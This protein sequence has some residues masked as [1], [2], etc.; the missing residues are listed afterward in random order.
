MRSSRRGNTAIIVGLSLAALLGAAAVVIDIGYGRLVRLELQNAADATALAAVTRFD[1]TDEG[2][3]DARATGVRIAA[4]NRAAGTGVTLD[5]NAANAPDGDI[6]LGVYD[7]TDGSFTPS[8]DAEVVNAA[9]V[10]ARIPDLGL[11]IAPMALNRPTLA[12]GAVSRTVREEGGAEAVDCF[13]PLGMPSCLVDR[14]ETGGL[15]NVTL[16]FQPT[17]IDNVG[18]ARPGA[19]PNASWS[20][21]QLTNCQQSGEISIGD[22]LGLQNG[23]AVSVLSEFVTAVESSSTRWDT[24][25]WG[26]LPARNAQSSIAAAKYGRTFEG[27]VPVFDGG[28]AY[29]TPGGGKFNGSAPISGFVWGA[30]YEVINKGPSSNRTIMMRLDFTKEYDVGTEVGGPDW[31]VKAS[32]PPRMLPM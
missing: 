1:G 22:S 16:K 29:C 7:E 31:S 32:E 21:S 24:A 14:Y 25:K 3:A 27:V 20:R 23:T 19:S 8:D 2:L 15:Q 10:R 26:A 9:E 12:V 13:I 18:Y 5:A 30:V 11:F 6:V 4:A 28:S 17:G